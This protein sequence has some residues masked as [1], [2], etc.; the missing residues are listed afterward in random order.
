MKRVRRTSALVLALGMA[1]AL[2]ACGEDSTE[3]S[4]DPSPTTATSSAPSAPTTAGAAATESAPPAQSTPVLGPDGFGALKLGMDRDQAEASG[5]V[6]PFVDEPVS[7]RCLWRSALSGAPADEGWVFHSETLGIAAI[8]APTGVQTVEGI[9]IGSPTAAVDAAYPDWD[10]S[11]HVMR[12]YA[13]VPGNDKA[14][15]RIAFSDGAVTDL[16]L[17]FIDQDC[18]E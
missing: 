11:D 14:V 17:Q 8:D 2:A 5:V 6:E 16:A 9:G 7:D 12:G 3:T 10:P 4:A 13:P 15:Y 1:G 18:Y